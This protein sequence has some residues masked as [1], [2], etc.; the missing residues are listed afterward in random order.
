MK[1][2]TMTTEPDIRYSALLVGIV[3]LLPLDGSGKAAL[4]Q[5]SQ[6]QP[7]L[8][9][10]VHR[11]GIVTSKRRKRPKWFIEFFQNTL[12]SIASQSEL[13]PEQVVY[14][15]KKCLHFQQPGF[16]S[17]SKSG[18]CVYPESRFTLNL[19][20]L[21]EDAWEIST[22]DGPLAQV[23]QAEVR[24][25]VFAQESL[26]QILPQEITEHTAVILFVKGTVFIIWPADKLYVDLPWSW[27][28]PHPT[29]GV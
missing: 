29:G 15:L 19:H 24:V 28:N 12:D 11:A 23:G 17:T 26:L 16:I 27:R 1:H 5:T 22:R 14:D 10:K 20:R 2:S 7:M 13:T 4:A 6:N 8:Q 3:L 21:S 9:G 18:F 25:F